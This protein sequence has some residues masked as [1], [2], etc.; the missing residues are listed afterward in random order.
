MESRRK[1]STSTTP[2]SQ[3]TTT[4]VP[5]RGNVSIVTLDWSENMT[6][7]N[8]TDNVLRDSWTKKEGA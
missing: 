3:V 6:D 5:L 1:D 7:Y 8:T 2:P 4:T